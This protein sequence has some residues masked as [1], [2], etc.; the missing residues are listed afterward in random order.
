MKSLV[1]Y[2][3]T[4]RSGKEFV[5]GQYDNGLHYGEIYDEWGQVESATICNTSWQVMGWLADK[6][7]SIFN[8]LF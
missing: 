3:D 7:E 5:S 8:G 2:R 1:E 4:L 6:G